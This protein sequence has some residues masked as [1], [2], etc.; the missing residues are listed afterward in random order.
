[1]AIATADPTTP[2]LTVPPD[3][4]AGLTR[5][6]EKFSEAMKGKVA[7]P[8]KP[9]ETKPAEPP[10]VVAPVKAPETIVPDVKMEPKVV[11]KA[12]EQKTTKL[13]ADNFKVLE[14]QRDDFKTQAETYQAKVAEL[15]KKLSETSTTI[16]PELEQTK[17]QLEAANKVLEEF[18]VEKSPQFQKHFG[19][20]EQ[21]AKTELAEAVGSEL[22]PKLEKILKG[23]GEWRDEQLE[24]MATELSSFKQSAIVKAYSD[25]KRVEKEKA[26]ELAKA[27]E[28]YA[29]L[30]E[31]EGEQQ[32][33]TATEEAKQV[34]SAFAGELQKFSTLPEFQPVDGNTEHN[35][36]VEANRKL[37]RSIA[38]AQLPPAERARLALLAV[39]GHNSIQ[40]DAIKDALIAKL[41]KQISE[42][43]GAN[44]TLK[45]GGAA[46]S[47]ETKPLGFAERVQKAMREGIPAP[48]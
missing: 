36:A 16:P 23:H 27:S 4:K 8:P 14:K 44:P 22:A 25:L 9:A 17:K 18:Y 1:M 39:K 11:E 48:A 20:R 12:P 29:K 32:K 38:T 33:L 15:E 45:G 24:E 21:Q 30:R 42:M 40:T 26:A 3:A 37:A 43:Q 2:P 41:Q 6:S 7:E 28:N 13:P 47:L 5:M 10:P 46:T 34:E 35:A 31:V 19:E